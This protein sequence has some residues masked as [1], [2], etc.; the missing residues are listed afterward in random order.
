MTKKKREKSSWKKRRN[1]A[2]LD[3]QRALKAERSR[4]EDEQNE[5]KGWSKGKIFG[6]VFML[7]L[8]VGIYSAWNYV[9]SLSSDN[10]NTIAQRAPLF[11]LTDID[12]NLISLDDLTGK[13]VVL[14]FFFPQCGYCDDE[15]VH[16][17]E[18]YSKY[19]RDQLEIISISPGS[20]SVQDLRDFKAGPN[21]FS[22]LEYEIS[23]IIAR[24][25]ETQDTIGQYDISG[26]PTTVII[27][28]QGFISE[29]S[30]F[31]GLTGVLELS[32]EI[33]QL[34]GR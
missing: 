13:V 10:S 26:Y 32:K 17:E 22:I 31:V 7:L 23:W 16:L 20:I 15:I 11:T 14:D 30:P 18:I 29:N 34:L 24:D 2:A 5:S 8:I 28:Q 25:L 33:D 21:R 12:G 27:D 1:Q 4:R 9:Q 6:L 19:S 3:H